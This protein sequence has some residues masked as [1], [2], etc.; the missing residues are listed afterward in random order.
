MSLGTVLQV[1]PFYATLSTVKVRGS[2]IMDAL[3]SGVS[4]YGGTSGT[5][6]FPQVWL[7][8]LASRPIPQRPDLV[9][10]A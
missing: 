2:D 10:G 8:S 7:S 4:L 3:Q 1:L 9:P 5:G 6:R